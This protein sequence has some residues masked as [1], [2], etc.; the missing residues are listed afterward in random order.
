MDLLKDRG[1]T[2]R[3]PRAAGRGAPDGRRRVEEED[4]C[5][6]VE[7]GVRGAALLTAGRDCSIGQTLQGSF[8]AVS[9][10]TC[11]SKY[12]LESSR[13]DLH[14]ALLCTAL[15]S[16]IFVKTLLNFFLNFAKFSKFLQNFGKILANF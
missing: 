12:A 6:A 3:N 13:R 11:G 15:Q 14:N 7:G 5:G 2:F 1:G 10:P 8:S 16:Q 4:V 9:K